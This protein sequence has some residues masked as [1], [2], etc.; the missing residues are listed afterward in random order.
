MSKSLCL[1]ALVGVSLLGAVIPADTQTSATYPTTALKSYTRARQV[2]DKAIEAAGGWTA[3]QAVKDVTRKG[4]GTAFNQGQSL[5]PMDA[6]TTRPVEFVSVADF[7]QTRS[8]NETVTTPSGGLSTKTRAVLKGDAAFGHNLLTNAVTPA[9]AAGLSGARNALRRDP[10]AILVTAARRAETLRWLGEDTLDGDKTDVVTF[11]DADGAQL[12]LS[13]SARTGLVSRIETLADN[14][15]L[16]DTA[17]ELVLSDYR[18]VS[19]IQLPFHAVTRV[20]GQV[21]QDVT[22]SEIK[23]NAPPETSLFEA[24]PA[25]P[26]VT[27]AGGAGNVEVTRLADDVFFLSGSS[28]NSLLVTFADHSLLVEAPLGDERSQALMAKIKE[29]APHKPVRYVVMTHY[30]FD[31]SGGVRS[32]MA[33]GATIVTTPDNKPFLETMAVTAHTI[34]PDAGR[35]APKPT[36]ETFSGKRTFTQGARTVEIYDVGP[37]PH[38]AEMAVA[39]L[40]KEK[41]LFVADLFTIPTQGPLAP[42]GAATRQ[43]AEKLKTL[44]LAVEKILPAHG[45]IGTIDELTSV[46]SARN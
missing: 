10:A 34:R 8:F 30:H 5:K 37:N 46:V 36:I 20:G 16:G 11:S 42:A 18:P 3:L 2:L 12:A 31:H 15:V 23:V 6:L 24:P 29:L 27:P 14:A 40:P 4:S 32:W 1:S 44:N 17:T 25:A 28:H 21:V 7:A 35:T 26:Q 33:Q 19:G 43:F 13:V 41:A 45:R 39:Y 38:V 9:T 22:Y